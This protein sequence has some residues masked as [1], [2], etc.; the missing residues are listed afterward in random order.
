MKVSM[1]TL[2]G[3]RRKLTVSVAAEQLDAVYQE[4]LRALAGS[5]RLDGFRKGKVPLKVVRQRFGPR[6]EREAL[7][8]LIQRSYEQAVRREKLNP[9]GPPQIDSKPPV[10]GENVEYTAVLEVQPEFALGDFSKIKISRPVVNIT[11][12][13]VE[14][15]LQKLCQQ[16]AQWNP[17]KRASARGDRVT[18]D[19]EG[20]VAGEPF[21]GGKAANVPLI[22][23]N[24]QMPED[25]ESQL[26]G[27]SAGQQRTVKVKFSE[28]YDKEWLR[29][30]KAVFEVTC[31]QVF[32]SALP[33][34]DAAFAREFGIEDG[35]LQALRD[36][37]R[38][39][40][41]SELAKGIRGYLKGRVMNGLVG[42]HKLD[43]PE[44]MI[45]AQ[46]RQLLQETMKRWGLKQADLERLPRES[47]EARARYQVT[48]QLV[49][50]R[51]INEKGIQADRETLH[52]IIRQAVADYENP[53]EMFDYYLND[54]HALQRFESLAVEERIVDEVLK[55]ADVV[56]KEMSFDEVMRLAHN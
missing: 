4:R 1:E 9:A 52:K 30:K 35:S 32:E 29:E 27:V 3:L 56:E 45:E 24:G 13:D 19:Y 31:R 28:D 34:L 23:G 5:V 10:A 39:Q 51:M 16:R 38:R 42:L 18:I 21:E 53:D 37:V 49:A 11:D 47:F 40:L 14:N 41:E 43:L 20:T 33:E 44:V 12:E 50:M 36:S 17:V 54:P 2:E 6:V 7:A 22:L 55:Q 46:V 15:T 8:D 25:F 48:L 26:E